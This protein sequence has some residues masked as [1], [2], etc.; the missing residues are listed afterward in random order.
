MEIFLID[1]STK[2]V[3]KIITQLERPIEDKYPIFREDKGILCYSPPK[4]LYVRE[5]K[6]KTYTFV[7]PTLDI[8]SSQIAIIP[9]PK[10]NVPKYHFIDLS[11]NLIQKTLLSQSSSIK[12]S[13]SMR[14]TALIHCTVESL[15]TIVQSPKIERLEQK[16]ES[17]SSNSFVDEQSPQNKQRLSTF[18]KSISTIACTNNHELIIINGI[19]N[20]NNITPRC[21]FQCS[22]CKKLL[23]NVETKL[24]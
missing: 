9:K 6:D 10:E 2:I 19:G 5:D 20:N 11:I 1:F 24:N 18:R 23:Q 16:L 21:F 22:Y 3:K 7:V 4:L 13:S 12:I 8:L 17:N 15:P 14:N